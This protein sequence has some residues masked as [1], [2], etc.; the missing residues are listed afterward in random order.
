MNVNTE[1]LPDQGELLEDIGRYRRLV[2]K[3]TYLTVTRSE[4]TFAMW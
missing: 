3:L 4:I 2:K 1:L